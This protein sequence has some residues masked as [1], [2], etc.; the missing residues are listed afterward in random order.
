MAC[1]RCRGTSSQLY[2]VDERTVPPDN[3]DSNYRMTREA[4]LDHVPL[5]P[6]QIHRMEGELEPEVA[7]AKYES[8]LRNRLPTGGRGVA[9]V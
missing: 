8:L 1:K 5:R 2:W 9:P 3:P 4:M 7:A 6:E